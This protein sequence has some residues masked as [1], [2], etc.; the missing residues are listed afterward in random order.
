MLNTP[1]ETVLLVAFRS[2]TGRKVKPDDVFDDGIGVL[3]TAKTT[4]ILSATILMLFKDAAVIVESLPVPDAK[5]R[6]VNSMSKMLLDILA[7]PIIT[8]DDSLNLV[9][10]RSTTETTTSSYLRSTNVG[11]DDGCEDGCCV[12]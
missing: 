9:K 4:L 10:L 7:A 6:L 2:E 1:M 5:E 3:M 12:G 11:C 8:F